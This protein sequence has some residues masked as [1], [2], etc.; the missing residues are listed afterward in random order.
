MRR[1]VEIAPQG[2]RPSI[3][4]R[5]VPPCEPPFDDEVEPAVWAT[6]HQL[7]FDWP[8]APPPP[9]P[10]PPP[11]PV[12]RSVVVGASPDAKVAVHR[13]MRLCVEVLNGH[14]PPAHLRPLSRPEEAAGVVAQGLAGA[15]RVA[16]LRRAA[17]RRPPRRAVP[18]AVIRLRV[19]EPRPGAVEAAAALVTG[20]RT[21]AMALRMELHQQSWAATTL[22]LI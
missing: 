21:W 18:V 22:R 19:C 20:E 9:P 14:R 15:R 7:A 11:P 12:H 13:F 6:A 10:A 2:P 4:L 8:P 5:R 3:S 1:T 16:D 17:G